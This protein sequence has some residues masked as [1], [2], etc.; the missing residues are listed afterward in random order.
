MIGNRCTECQNGFYDL[1]INNPRGC[2]ECYC[3]GITH[4]CTE[5]DLPVKIVH[6]E[7]AHWKVTDLR[8]SQTVPTHPSEDFP[9]A[10]REALM[11]LVSF[12]PNDK[13]FYW[14]A[15]EEY[16]GAKVDELGIFE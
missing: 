10:T 11:D 9:G 13:I 4:R 1:N 3:F 15:P 7:P 16:V 8:N 6:E 5:S 14:R 2:S 12:Q